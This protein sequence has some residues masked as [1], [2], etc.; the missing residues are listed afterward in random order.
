MTGSPL[1]DYERARH[2]RQRL[3]DAAWSDLLR[4]LTLRRPVSVNHIAPVVL[5]ADPVLIEM[6]TPDRG[7]ELLA[8]PRGQS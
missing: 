8:T 7:R 6:I 2:V 1:E 4:T 3:L 5:F